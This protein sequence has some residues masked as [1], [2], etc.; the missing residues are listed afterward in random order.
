MP[1]NSAD[2]LVVND[3]P[4]VVAEAEPCNHDSASLET[5]RCYSPVI[6]RCFEF[7]SLYYDK[8]VDTLHEIRFFHLE[9]AWHR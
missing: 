9:L 1:T 4:V 3:E 7:R 8:V 5:G 6:R 2:G